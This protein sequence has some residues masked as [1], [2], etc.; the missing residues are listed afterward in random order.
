MRLI[1][2]RLLVGLSGVEV[3]CRECFGA[4]GVGDDAGAVGNDY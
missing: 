3:V 4:D 1:N 2:F